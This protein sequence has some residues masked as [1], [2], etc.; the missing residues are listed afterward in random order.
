M[1][2]IKTCIQEVW[3]GS[4]WFHVDL[5][6]KHSMRIEHT[7]FGV[8]TRNHTDHTTQLKWNA[9]RK[10]INFYTAGPHFLFKLSEKRQPLWVTLKCFDTKFKKRSIARLDWLVCVGGVGIWRA[11]YLAVCDTVL[12]AVCVGGPAIKRWNLLFVLRL[13]CIVPHRGNELNKENVWRK[14][15]A[16]WC[17]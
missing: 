12:P 7:M 6:P 2:D 11:Y 13:C 5:K 10:E 1:S 9:D 3:I 8:W 4:I 14:A 16:H 15:Q 17:T